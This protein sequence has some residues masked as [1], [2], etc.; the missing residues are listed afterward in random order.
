MAGPWKQPKSASDK[1]K[2]RKS[3]DTLWRVEWQHVE[4]KLTLKGRYYNPPPE[5]QMDYMGIQ[6]SDSDLE[7]DLYEQKELKEME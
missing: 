6:E 3:T 2:N 1:S 4:S 7:L 5:A